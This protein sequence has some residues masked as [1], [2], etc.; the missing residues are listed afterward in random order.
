VTAAIVLAVCCLA[1]TIGGWWWYL[2]RYRPRR[3]TRS[4]AAAPSGSAGRAPAA[5]SRGG[6]SRS[7]VQ[8]RWSGRRPRLEL[9]EDG[10]RDTGQQIRFCLDCAAERVEDQPSS[11]LEP[12]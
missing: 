2:T 6:S 10:L 5:R 1:V 9:T 8:H 3:K 4:A 11:E 12:K 7:Y